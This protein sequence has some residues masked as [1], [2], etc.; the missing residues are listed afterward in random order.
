MFDAPGESW[1][2]IHAALTQGLRGLPGGSTLAQLLAEKRGVRNIMDLPDLTI[3][4]ILQWIDAHRARTAKWPNQKSGVVLSAPEETWGNIHAALYVGRRGLPGGS[5]L[6]KLLA[7]ERES[8]M[9]ST[10][11]PDHRANSA[12]DG[13][14]LGKNW[15]VA[16]PKSG[17]VLGAP[18]E[19]WGNVENS[20]NRG[21]RGLP[22]GFSLAKLRTVKR[23]VRSKTYPPDLHVDQLL[24]WADAHRQKTGKWPTR[25]SGAVLCAPGEKWVNLNTALYLGQRGLPGGSSLA[26]L[27]RQ[28]R[29]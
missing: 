11:G 10:S 7:E 12:M 8:E 19:A 1:A 14:P 28:E 26:K 4:L 18:G 6:A 2:N 23:G 16:E 9:F 29:G 13:W 21:R 24:Q 5:T 17:A 20:L 27:L 25:G 3:G 22:S 15:P